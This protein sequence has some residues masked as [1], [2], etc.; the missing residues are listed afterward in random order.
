M[1]EL[2]SE[3]NAKLVLI[4]DELVER[5]IVVTEDLNAVQSQIDAKLEEAKVYKS[6][7]ESSKE[8]IKVFEEEIESLKKDLEELTAKFSN[9]DLN[10]IVEAANKEINGKIAIRQKE[11]T[12][13][14]ERINELTERARTIKDLLVNLKQDKETKKTKLDNL[15]DAIYY[16]E[17][18]FNR[19]IEYSSNNP[20]SLVY[21]PVDV[22][23][24]EYEDIEVDDVKTKEVVLDESPVFEEIDNI[25]K[26]ETRVD[27]ERD[28][29]EVVDTEPKEVL[30]SDPLA[31]DKVE[32][33]IAAKVNYKKEEVVEEE[34]ELETK[35]DNVLD[36]TSTIDMFKDLKEEHL[37]NYEGSLYEHDK[38]ERIDFKTLNDTINAEYENIFGSSDE[39]ELPD[40]TALFKIQSEGNLFDNPTFEEPVQD[41]S[42]LTKIDYDAVNLTGLNSVEST[43]NIDD[44]FGNI[45]EDMLNST[46]T[47][48][49]SLDSLNSEP[50][51]TNTV[52]N[53]AANVIE[54]NVVENITAPEE[55]VQEDEQKEEIDISKTPT[56]DRGSSNEEF[57][58]NFFTTN[59]LDYSKFSTEN[60]ELLKNKFSP[61]NY[62]KVLDVLKK[63]NVNLD[64]IYDAPRVFEMDP[65]ELD[66]IIAKLLLA[67]QTTTN[68]SY[69]ISSLVYVSADSLQQVIDTYGN[70]IKDT[71]ITEI[72]TKAKH[73]NEM[74]DK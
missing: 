34:K 62:S 42:E 27:I 63:N 71:D 16:Y 19:I 39:I 36:E 40:D 41:T 32:D 58:S 48:E 59:K 51:V 12:K 61:I 35:N 14:T 52:E 37:N 46:L 25:E 53:T 47:G 57:M 26:D 55:P 44:L 72:I 8:S 64:Y 66:S 2:I 68:I 21:L 20:E 28:E 23:E 15:N 65:N 56:Y 4:I 33:A 43:D 69:V 9:R 30:V 67:N 70:S 29:E 7:V 6:S 11:I 73:L 22:S 17:Q 74:G 18:E 13:Q 24:V 3:I 60:Q 1:R 5:R 50:V 31:L 38:T 10:A 54:E 45:S 49:T